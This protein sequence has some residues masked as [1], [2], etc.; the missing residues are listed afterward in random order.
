MRTDHNICTGRVFMYLADDDLSCCGGNPL[1]IL[2][3]SKQR[4]HNSTIM[5]EQMDP[6]VVFFLFEV[7]VIEMISANSDFYSFAHK[8]N[9]RIREKD[10]AEWVAFTPTRI[11]GWVLPP[12]PEEED[13]N[14][15]AV[16][17]NLDGAGVG[18]YNMM[19]PSTHP[20]HYP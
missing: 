16:T 20:L 9:G 5:A 10:D 13:T 19:R 4:H 8:S 11:C 6:C 3:V 14:Y 17:T 15:L 7:P 12:P 18:L 2:D 1:S